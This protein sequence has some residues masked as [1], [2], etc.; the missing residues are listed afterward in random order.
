MIKYTVDWIFGFFPQNTYMDML[1][2]FI[3]D[4]IKIIFILFAMIFIISYFRSFMPLSKIKKWLEKSHYGSG[5]FMASL[6][7]AITPFCSC[8]SVPIFISF[9]RIGVPLGITLS[10]LITSPIVNQYLVAIM[11][12]EFGAKIAFTY[13]L[14]GIVI[15][16]VT[17]I[18]L[19]R[20]GLEKLVR[21]DIRVNECLNGKVK[22]QKDRFDYSFDEASSIVKKLWL[23]ILAG[24]FIGAL[25]H[26]FVPQ[27]FITSIINRGGIFTV[28]IA[29]LLGVPIYGSCAVLIP[30]AVVL[31][32]KGVP[33]GTALAFL[34]AASAL[35][36]PEAVILKRAM[37]MKLIV[38]F[39]VVVTIAIIV[40]GYVINYLEPYLV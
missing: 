9:L 20:F 37:K 23:W 21:R 2:F 17:G 18:I 31:F 40:I 11:L 32:Q 6:F 1:N 19:Q 34:M 13:A 25:I 7:G 15:G 33:L 30:I 12:G 29:A 22:T 8:S 14:S 27:E 24:V 4:S 26:N 28:P 39:Y 36:L 38:I 3:Y 35:S 5:N 16:T 10:F